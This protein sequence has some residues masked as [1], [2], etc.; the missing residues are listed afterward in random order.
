MTVYEKIINYIDE[1]NAEVTL[2]ELARF[3]GYS[4][5]QVYRIFKAHNNVP[6]MEYIR[7]RKLH[8]A[9]RALRSRKRLLDIALDHGFETQSGF[10]KAFVGVFG[11]SPSEYGKRS[12]KMNNELEDRIKE[13]TYQINNLPNL[14]NAPKNV[15]LLVELL[16]YSERGNTYAKAGL[17]DEALADYA[18][19]IERMPDPSVARDVDGRTRLKRA[20][21]YIE[22]NQ[23]NKA[24]D[25]VDAYF[26][27][28]RRLNESAS[29]EYLNTW[30]FWNYP[31]AYLTRGRIYEDLGMR[32]NAALDYKR[33]LE[34]TFDETV[35]P[36]DAPKWDVNE[37]QPKWCANAQ[38]EWLQDIYAE[39]RERL[40]MLTH[41]P[42]PSA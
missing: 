2:A 41:S 16:V 42:P 24:M 20:V 3:T 22:L 15:P 17:Y 39:A 12:G 23:Y 18:K 8:A 28:L 11:C 14:K 26:G 21:I 32:D 6:I 33:V 37:Q 29:T 4:E 35:L 36:L 9:A 40:K 31:F 1:R 30:D 10:Y 38:R 34:I 27:R 7:K 19:V 5:R 13:L 25:D